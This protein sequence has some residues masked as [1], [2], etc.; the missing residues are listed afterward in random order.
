MHLLNFFRRFLA[1]KA[2]RKRRILLLLLHLELFK[3]DKNM[4]DTY[5]DLMYSIQMDKGIG[6]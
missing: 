3:E 6:G 4:L 1:R 2:M 5:A